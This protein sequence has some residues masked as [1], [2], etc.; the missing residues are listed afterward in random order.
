LAP[1]SIALTLWVIGPFDMAGQMRYTWPM[2]IDVPLTSHLEQFVRDQLTRGGFANEGDVVRAALQL[3][4]FQSQSSSTSAAARPA[5]DHPWN[6][7]GHNQQ[8]DD[9]AGKK[10]PTLNVK[11]RSPRGLLADIPSHISAEEI[12]KARNEMWASLSH[13]DAR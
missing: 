5:H 9:L 4:A 13:R 12:K 6:Q 11:R 8:I 7:T 3:L 1:Q 2:N 10:L